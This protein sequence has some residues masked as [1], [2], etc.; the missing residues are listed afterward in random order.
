MAEELVLYPLYETLLGSK[1]A[2]M[3]KSDREQH[4]EAKTVLS[5][6]ESG[7]QSAIIVIGFKLI[8]TLR[9]IER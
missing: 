8:C 7:F 2:E 3:A 4:L 1:G 6:L 5:K 9:C